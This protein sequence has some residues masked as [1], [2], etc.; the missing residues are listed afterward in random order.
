MASPE[1]L[2]RQIPAIVV[3]IKIKSAGRAPRHLGHAH[4][5]GGVTMVGDVAAGNDLPEL[6]VDVKGALGCEFLPVR[7]V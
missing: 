4:V 7:P 1:V 3:I 5:G 6:V 2:G